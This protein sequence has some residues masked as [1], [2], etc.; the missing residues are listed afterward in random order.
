MEEQE[1]H[2]NARLLA[3]GIEDIPW[4]SVNPDEV[5]TNMVFF[6]VDVAT[7]PMSEF[8]EA[9]R[10]AEV[11]MRPTAPRRVRAVTHLDV[12]RKDIERAVEVFHQ[13]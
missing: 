13:V 10:R 3:E 11:L 6:D 9:L 12:N 1:D 7:R 4:I 2:E 8:I 5:E